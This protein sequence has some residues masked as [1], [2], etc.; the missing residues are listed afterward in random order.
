MS[1]PAKKHMYRIQ[2]EDNTYQIVDLTTT[3]YNA[4]GD[5]LVSGEYAIKLKDY[6]LRLKDIRTITFLPPAP[7]P[8]NEEKAAMKNQAEHQIS[9]WGFVDPETLAWLAANGIDVYKKEG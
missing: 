5:S 4:V 2:Y 9:E 3:D 8:T 1:T 7:E 6:I